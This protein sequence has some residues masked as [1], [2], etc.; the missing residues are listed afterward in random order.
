MKTFDK[1]DVYS[2]SNAEKAK[3]YIG[4]QGYFGDSIAELDNK[5]QGVFKNILTDIF[6]SD[7]DRASFPFGN[8]DEETWSLFLPADKVKEVEEPK[9]WRAFKDLSEFANTLEL[10]KLIGAEIGFRYKDDHTISSQAIIT[11]IE[12]HS[13]NNIVITL[14][15][16][17]WGIRRL[18]QELEWLDRD[19]KYKP[20][21]VIDES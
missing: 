2:W 4:K 13:T 21:G 5:I 1:K 3:Q 10:D 18:F 19:G 16:Q 14:G 12:F 8:D 7:T 11:R 20:F 6:A 15:G 17:G 9:K